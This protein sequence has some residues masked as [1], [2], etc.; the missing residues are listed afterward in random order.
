[1][2]VGV[3]SNQKNRYTDFKVIKV[4]QTHGL[5]LLKEVLLASSPARIRICISE[6]KGYGSH[7]QQNEVLK[8]GNKLRHLGGTD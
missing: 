4:K 8:V 5:S 2:T 1:M 7:L 6:L 3:S